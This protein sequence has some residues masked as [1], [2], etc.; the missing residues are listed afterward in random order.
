MVR[1]CFLRCMCS[2]RCVYRGAPSRADGRMRGARRNPRI[3]DSI[4]LII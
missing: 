4:F 2:L 1:T 3:M